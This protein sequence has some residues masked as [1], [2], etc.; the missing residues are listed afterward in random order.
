MGRVW[1]EKWV[2]TIFMHPCHTCLP[3]LSLCIFH[4]C[5]QYLVFPV[6][7]VGRIYI[8]KICIIIASTELLYTYNCI[9]PSVDWLK[10][11]IRAKDG[12]K[13]EHNGIKVEFV[14][15]IGEFIW[16]SLAFFWTRYVHVQKMI[17]LTIRN[18]LWQKSPIWVCFLGAGTGKSGGTETYST[19]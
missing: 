14:G 4:W 8:R 5:R 16:C 6:Y 12:R 18:E 15:H 3:Y 1:K 11:Q 19:L 9:P 10:V 17:L 13:V 7:T 2:T